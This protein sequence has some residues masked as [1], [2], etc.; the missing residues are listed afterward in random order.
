[1]RKMYRVNALMALAIILGGCVGGNTNESSSSTNSAPPNISSAPPSSSSII[2]SSVSSSV[3]AQTSS[4][5]STASNLQAP[6]EYTQMCSFCHGD[7]GINSLDP[8]ATPL[9]LSIESQYGKF[10]RVTMSRMPPQDIGACDNACAVK[11]KNWVIARNNLTEAAPSQ[12]SSSVAPPAEDARFVS[13]LA[14]N[15]GG[16][17]VTGASGVQYKADEGFTGGTAGNQVGAFSQVA[18]TD[19]DAVFFTERYGESSYA[20]DVPNGFYTVELGFI[21]LIHDQTEGKRVF[22]VAV[23]GDVKLQ[24]IDPTAQAGGTRAALIEE[25]E[26]I[27]VTD[28]KMNID[29]QAVTFNPSVSFINIKRPETPE[30]QYNRMCEHCH[31]GP[32]G[33]GRTPL[34]DSLVASRCLSC[35]NRNGLISYITDNMPFE[36]GNTCVGE[37]AEDMADYILGNFA[38]YGGRPD[39]TLPDFLD[40]GG[41]TGA[42]GS[43]DVGESIIR[44]VARFDY[45]R[46]VKDLFSIEGTFI[47]GFSADQ[48]IGGFSQGGFSIN[49]SR[50]VSTGQVR[51]YFDVAS[52]VSE[53]AVANKSGWLNCAAEND[54]CAESV[55]DTI[56]R[57]AFRKPVSSAEKTRLM[58]LYT[59]A[60][61][62]EDFDRGLMTLIQGILTVPQFLYYVEIGEGNGDVKRLTQY[63]LAARMALFLWR[64]V[65]D[66]AL[67]DRA[68]NNQLAT[69]AQIRTEL[70]RMLSDARAR[71]VVSLFHSE[72][73]NIS[74]PRSGDGFDEQ[75]AALEDFNRIIEAI[76]FG[77]LDL[78]GDG[79]NDQGSVRDLF[80]VDFGYL[81]ADT[82]AFYGASGGALASGSD[83]FDLYKLDANRRGGLLARA[84]F[85]RSNGT[86][87]TRGLFVREH[88]LCGTIPTPPPDAAD[89]E[90][91]QTDGKNPRE[92]FALHTEDPGCGGCHALMDPLG[93]PMDNFD[94]QGQWRTEYGGG[95]QVDANG[96]FLR[97]DIDGNFVGLHEMQQRLTQSQQVQ[98]CYAFNWFQFATGRDPSTEDA[99]SLGQINQQSGN[100]ILDLITSIVLSDSFRNRRTAL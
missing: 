45:N 70:E 13:F 72:W 14:I 40:K 5:S 87:T 28:G 48:L 78:N 77:D 60:K 69:D 86:P 100:S 96:R 33:E 61:N 68:A 95:F 94:K 42:C 81:N 50:L 39:V 73:M 88:V 51:Q 52:R 56:G 19:E 79:S 59:A 7:N 58:S 4:A 55:I 26:G 36:Y 92:L 65:P 82:K 17:A 31:G 20:L 66:D 34:G 43:E 49:S 8:N 41:N 16:D 93:F 46:M 1:M 23:E 9:N 32:T 18:N 74:Q 35:G 22:N 90:Q 75:V 3:P 6:T 12:S 63:E 30:D 97:T 44:R 2:S 21:E 11:I 27:E 64:S 91:S 53:E 29:F 38:G 54:Q 10:E 71:D 98:E 80:T 47:N 83:G 25:V 57:R 62:A 76:T 24:N 67:M 84:P 15:V 85:L 89:A 37:C 99:C